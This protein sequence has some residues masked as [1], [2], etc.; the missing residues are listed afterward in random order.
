MYNLYVRRGI[1]CLFYLIFFA[2]FTAF[3]QKESSPHKNY[4]T[5]RDRLIRYLE[6]NSTDAKPIVDRFES[7]I[8]K[9]YTSIRADNK[10][11]VTEKEKSIRSLVFL[12][13]E[14]NTSLIQRKLSI[15]DIAGT[16]KTYNDVL[17]AI[18]THKPLDN[19]L[20][21]VG[22][23]RTQLIASAFTQ[24]K[25]HTLLDDIATYKR[26]IDNPEFILQFLESNPGFRLADSL[27]MYAAAYDPLKLAFY[28]QKNRPVI[29]NRVRSTSNIYIRQIALISDNKNASELL[30]F[31]TQMARREIT[32]EE[33]LHKRTE[34][35]T[36]F[37]L[38][39]NTLQSSIRSGE[40]DFMFIKPLRQ[41]LHQKAVSFYVNQ[42]NELHD[43]SESV[44][45][46]SVKDLRPQ[47]LYYIITTSGEDLYTSSYLGLYKRLMEQLKP[48]PADSLFDLVQYDNFRAFIR[49]AANYNV[50]NDFLG[51]LSPEK[52]KSI[53]KQFIYGIDAD[54]NTALEKAM[55]IADSFTGIGEATEVNQFIQSE[56]QSNLNR[57]KA[58]RDFLGTRL[59]SILADIL[60]LVNKDA[61]AGQVWAKLGDYET[62]KHK[63]LENQRGEIIEVVLFYGDEDGVSSFN[64]FLRHYN[65]KKKWEI[66]KNH[67]WINIRSLTDPSLIIYAN[68]P[69]DIKDQLDLKAQDSLV[70]YLG[71]QSQEPSVLVHRGHSYHLDK[72]LNRLTPSVKLAI[73][74]SCGGYNKAI[75]VASINPDVQVIGS[76]KTGAK[77]IN[78]PI[79]DEI[80]ENLIN[81]KDLNWPEIWK[82]LEKQFSKDP[83]ALNLFNEYF[84]PGENLG[85][86]V[87][88]LFNY[89]K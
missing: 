74:G 82:N 12:I 58:A 18:I 41:A 68:L 61:H 89:Y 2:S 13:K 21:P 76:K 28:F 87:L 70:A 59:Y 6:V 78:D 52:K 84:P 67:N 47:D 75:S 34:V 9:I 88:K 49:L 44:R 24:F 32:P 7:D 29:G 14:L 31:I 79:I 15:Y 37:Q 51:R 57:C 69:L 40:S 20:A 50:L 38:L 3:A 46:A 65:D 25:E 36:Y 83:G 62:L 66:V 56:L 19:L 30:P 1:Y 81:K 53:L 26:V 23:R 22:P 45:F 10:L 5:E 35:L 77:S 72:T 55:D 11:S 16:V 63:S 86:F 4:R 39:V 54:P 71:R 43:A 80:N 48:Q 8:N 60:S 17:R 85:L 64:N 33:I 27:L 73:L 42:V